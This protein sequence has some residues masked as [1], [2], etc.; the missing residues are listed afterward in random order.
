M[1]VPSTINGFT[2]CAAS[3]GGQRTCRE[4]SGKFRELCH[5]LR[6]WPIPVAERSL[7]G[8]KSES[9]SFKWN[10]FRLLI[11]F[12]G[13]T[14]KEELWKKLFIQFFLTIPLLHPLLVPPGKSRRSY[15]TLGR[16]LK[17]GWGDLPRSLL[18]NSEDCAE[19]LRVFSFRKFLLNP[20]VVWN[21]LP[22]MAGFKVK[23][24]PRCSE[25]RTKPIT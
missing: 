9:L 23:T 3:D 15:R 13:K 7:E 19:T 11:V 4:S 18:V 14:G 20:S 24:K 22:L 8:S 25:I 21:V 12:I 10:F 16:K 6:Y 1:S 2:I 5:L 17:M